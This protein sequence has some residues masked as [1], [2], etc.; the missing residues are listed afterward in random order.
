MYLSIG[1]LVGVAALGWLAGMATFHRS[2]RWCRR[3]G[4]ILNCPD[5]AEP[6]TCPR[7]GT[8]HGRPRPPEAAR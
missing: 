3:C 1:A 7:T 4:Q 6:N 8:G 2:L 5:C